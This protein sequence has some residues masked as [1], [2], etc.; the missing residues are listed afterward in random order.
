M[1]KSIGGKV[2]GGIPTMFVFQR[3]TVVSQY[4]STRVAETASGG[5]LEYAAVLS[6][7]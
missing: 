1:P 6:G 3:N 2:K 4:K 5:K 7:S